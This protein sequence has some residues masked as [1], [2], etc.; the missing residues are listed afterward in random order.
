[1]GG[2]VAVLSKD[3]QFYVEPFQL[4]ENPADSSRRTREFNG[5]WL[6]CIDRD[7]HSCLVNQF[8]YFLKPNG[9]PV[10]IVLGEGALER[11]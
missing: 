11:L 10:I 6:T 8:G 3:F 4:G 5:R 7:A 1:M 9:L 2:V